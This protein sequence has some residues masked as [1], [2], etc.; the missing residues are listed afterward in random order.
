M[1][2][3]AEQQSA[4]QRGS[5]AAARTVAALDGDPGRAVDVFGN[6]ERRR[7]WLM[8]KPL[9]NLYGFYDRQNDTAGITLHNGHPL[10]LQRFT[11]AHE[12][13]HH[14]LKH[15]Q[16]VDQ[17]Y[18]LYS[19]SLDLP[20]QEVEAQAFA[21]DFL[22]PEQLLNRA[23]DRVGIPGEPGQISALDAYQLSL[24]MGSSYRATLTQLQRTG[25][26]YRDVA[27]SL[28]TVQPIDIKAEIAD[29]E[30]PANSRSDVW[31][32]TEMLA[33]RQL[34]L[35]LGDELH[36]R[37]PEIPSAGYRWDAQLEGMENALELVSDDYE[38]QG[39]LNEARIGER[40]RRHLWLRA[41][42]AGHGH[43][44]LTLERPWEE[45]T[46]PAEMLRVPLR[47][48]QKRTGELDEGTSRL[49]RHLP[50]LA[51]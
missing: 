37:L 2:S 46:K 22:M 40:P 50:E 42:Q 7:V 23:M 32:L 4:R 35:R 36:V 9:G 14:V 44:R 1:P 38:E 10:S 16:S 24:E 48:F 45:S 43:L 41:W 12:L 6:I 25:R 20:F 13:G 18:E 11:A 3:W 39:S 5:L 27:E 30:K 17:P 51:V 34:R 31:L 8:F 33:G 49:Q 28:R 21:A 29:G 15:R 47:I 19:G 26:I